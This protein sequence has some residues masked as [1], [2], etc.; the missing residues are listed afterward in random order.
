MFCSHCGCEASGNF[1]YSC[2]SMLN[3]SRPGATPTLAAS[4]LPLPAMRGDWSDEVRYDVLLC[5]DE[6][7]QRIAAASR[8]RGQHISAEE[9]LAAFDALAPTG[10]PLGKLMSIVQPLYS[11]WGIKTGKTAT[12][13]Y[14]L[15]AGRVLVAIL[16][17][18]AAQ[19]IELM[20][21]RE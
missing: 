8:N 6:V 14:C 7:R 4:T 3:G 16:C 13:V 12:H 11:R 5:L 17:S 2:G 18:L 15:P 20:P 21:H 9:L 10:V 1:C 19:G